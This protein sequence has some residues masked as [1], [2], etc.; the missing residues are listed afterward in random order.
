[1]VSDSWVLFAYPSGSVN[2][3][4]LVP[5]KWGQKLLIKTEFLKTKLSLKAKSNTSL[6][7]II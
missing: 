4:Y 2:T 1:M 7:Y 5:S 3:S 6:F